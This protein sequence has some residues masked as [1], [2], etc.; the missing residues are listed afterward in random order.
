L[1]QMPMFSARSATARL[2]SNAKLF[3]MR[4]GN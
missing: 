2:V 4:F 3:K 1:N